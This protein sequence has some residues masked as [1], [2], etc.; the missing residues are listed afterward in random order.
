MS[1]MD[2]ITENLSRA[3]MSALKTDDPRLHEVEAVFKMIRNDDLIHVDLIAAWVMGQDAEF[4]GKL[5]NDLQE[6]AAE[7][8]HDERQRQGWPVMGTTV[9]D[10][11]A[12]CIRQA[13]R[14]HLLGDAQ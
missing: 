14:G 2:A 7:E 1:R 8:E 10:F 13:G 11:A 12:H 6:L 4:R 5:M 9:T 3:V